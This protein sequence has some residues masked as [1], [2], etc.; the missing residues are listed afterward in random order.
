M[1]T[2]IPKQLREDFFRAVVETVTD[3]VALVS[4]DFKI[5][6]HNKMVSIEPI[7]DFDMEIFV[8]WLKEIA[9]VVVHVGYANYNQYIPE[10]TLEKTADLIKELSSF[11]KVKIL[12]VREK[13]T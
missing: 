8:N 6:Y 10:P 5:L 7:M 12:R 11:T 13:Y 4:K 9:P 3:P 2:D 1:A